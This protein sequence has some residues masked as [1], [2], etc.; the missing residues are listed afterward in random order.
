MKKSKC[1]ISK[2]MLSLKK[3]KKLNMKFYIGDIKCYE[4][5]FDFRTHCRHL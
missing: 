3:I 4:L 2:D 1:L 5:I